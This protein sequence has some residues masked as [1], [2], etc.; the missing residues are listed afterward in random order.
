MARL[1]R[2]RGLA[3]VY[4]R[5]SNVFELLKMVIVVILIVTAKASRFSFPGLYLFQIY[6]FHVSKGLLFLFR[7]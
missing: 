5:Q 1:P 6:L 4:D 2:L 3:K 7:A